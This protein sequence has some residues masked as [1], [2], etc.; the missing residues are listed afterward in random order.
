MIIDYISP[1]K[2][3][4]L[5]VWLDWN[6]HAYRVS[7]GICIL[8]ILGHYEYSTIYPM[9]LGDFTT[10]LFVGFCLWSVYIVVFKGYGVG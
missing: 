1:E 2:L 7:L 8:I 3:P 10:I 4:D 6:F 9:T 5:I